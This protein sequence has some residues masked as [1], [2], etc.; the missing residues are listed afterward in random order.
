M[1]TEIRGQRG[2]DE[3]ESGVRTERSNGPIVENSGL[4]P[5]RTVSRRPRGGCGLISLRGSSWQMTDAGGF[6]EG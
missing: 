6:M 3:L 1:F 5:L 4:G 2:K